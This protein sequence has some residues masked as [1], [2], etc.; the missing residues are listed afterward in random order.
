MSAVS[1]SN[2][3]RCADGADDTTPG[4]KLPSGRAVPCRGSSPPG[5][6]RR[7]PPRRLSQY[8]R[9]VQSY[10]DKLTSWLVAS[11]LCAI[12]NHK[13]VVVY[14]KIRS[15][16]HTDCGSCGYSVLLPNEGDSDDSEDEEEEEEE[17]WRA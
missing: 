7:R 17:L 16:T 10:R 9:I 1:S 6:R 14:P 13:W 11:L 8:G 4:S 12:C 15:F 3:K 2:A 5:R